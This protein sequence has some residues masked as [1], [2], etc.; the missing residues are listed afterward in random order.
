MMSTE[1]K[2]WVAIDEALDQIMRST[3]CSRRVARKKLAAKMKSGEVHYKRTL[4]PPQPYLPPEEAAEQ[5]SEDP[6]NIWVQLDVFLLQANFTKDEIM[7]EL[8]SGRLMTEASDSVHMAV[9]LRKQV[10]PAQI[11]VSGQALVNW[12]SNPATPRY[13]VEKWLSGLSQRKN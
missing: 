5:F 9:I 11:M 3:G 4:E 7:G 8:R 2:D 12:M 13:L 1:K 6:R 10:S